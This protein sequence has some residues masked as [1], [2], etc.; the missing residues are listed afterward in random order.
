MSMSRQSLSP[1]A[2]QQAEQADQYGCQGEGAGDRHALLP[3]AA[4]CIPGDLAIT[5]I[6]VYLARQSQAA[7]RVEQEGMLLPT[8]R[9][10]AD[11]QSAS[12]Q[13]AWEN[14]GPISA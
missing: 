12:D 1:E 9:T 2:D 11:M 3:F 4:L 8:P 7:A 13:R 6:P 14:P 5:R 10:T